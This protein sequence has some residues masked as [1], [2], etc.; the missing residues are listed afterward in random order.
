MEQ[1][2]SEDQANAIYFTILDRFPRCKSYLDAAFS[3]ECTDASSAPSKQCL[4][5]EKELN[6]CMM[7]YLCRN[8]AEAIKKCTKGTNPFLLRL[9]ELRELGCYFPLQKKMEECLTARTEAVEREEKRL[10]IAPRPPRTSR[11]PAGSK[12]IAP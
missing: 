12:H 5:M 8:E 7:E 10:G 9:E 3:S 6:W 4:M 11:T 1:R 2:V